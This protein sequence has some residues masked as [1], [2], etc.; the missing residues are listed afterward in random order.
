MAEI[1][2]D[3]RN[4]AG[5]IVGP[6]PI[7]TATN[8]HQEKRVDEAGSFSFDMPASDDKHLD[9]VHNGTVEIYSNLTGIAVQL[10]AGVVE[11]IQ[12][13]VGDPSMINV[14]GGDLLRELARYPVGDTRIY[15][16]EWKSLSGGVGEVWWIDGAGYDAD[17]NLTEAYDGD[18]GTYTDPTFKLGDHWWLCVGTDMPSTADKYLLKTV[19]GELVG[20]G[21]QYQY[22]SDATGWTDFT[23]LTDGTKVGSII[24]AQDGT[25]SWDRPVD[26][27]RNRI[28]PTSGSKFWRRIRVDKLAT[29]ATA[30]DIS[31]YEIESY[32]DTPSTAGVEI[33][34]TL[35][36]YY[37]GG[38]WAVVSTATS[39]AAYLS[40]NGESVLTALQVLAES[41]G[42]HFILGTGREITWIGPASTW[43]LGDYGA[44]GDVTGEEAELAN[45]HNLLITN[46]SKVTDTAELITRIVPFAGSGAQR[47]DLSNATST[48]PAGYTLVVNPASPIQ[49][50]LENDAAVATYG[51]VAVS[52]FF[53][54]ILNQADGS[55]SMGPVYA[56]NQLYD[57]AKT[58]LDTHCVPATHYELSVAGVRDYP[59]ALVSPATKQ[60]IV[61]QEWTDGVKTLDINTYPSSPLYVMAVDYQI[62]AEGAL[63]A[64]MEVSNV[65]RQAET[66]ASVTVDTIQTV[67]QLTGGVKSMTGGSSNIPDHLHTTFGVDGGKLKDVILQ[68]S[69]DSRVERIVSVDNQPGG[70]NYRTPLLIKGG[71]GAHGEFWAN[72]G[73]V[74]LEGGDGDIPGDIRLRDQASKISAIMDTTEL[75]SGDKIFTW[76]NKSGTIATTDDIGG[77]SGDVAGPAGAVDSN[78]AAF[79]T[80]T[81]KKIK[82]SGYNAASF[83]AALGADDNYVTDAEKIVIGNT[84]GTN[85]GDNAANSQI[86]V[87][88]VGSEIDTGTDDAKFVTAKA[89]NDSHNVP[90]VAPSTAGNYMKSN[91]TDW[92]SANWPTVT[93]IVP[94]HRDGDNDTVY[95]KTYNSNTRVRFWAFYLPFRIVISQIVIKTGATVTQ[96]GTM[97]LGIY[98]EDGQTKYI[99]VTTPTLSA[100]STVYAVAVS[101]SVTLL[102]GVY[103]GAIVCIGTTN[104]TLK[105]NPG[106]ADQANWV[107]NSKAVEEGYHDYASAGVVPASFSPTA[108]LTFSSQS[109]LIMR[110]DT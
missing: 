4:V 80:N 60:H 37:S 102:P 64:S 99:D 19:N 90:D 106:S 35:A 33:L 18:G 16:Q 41:T 3:V 15:G 110:F 8:W 32:L 75:D 30:G 108:D 20:T 36:N 97:Q 1:W 53:N 84:S 72:G 17:R 67:R 94:K 21:E 31:I 24:F 63:L 48:P 74:I 105:V 5:T 93:S 101:P 92:I 7:T 42:D 27:V 81:G 79:D 9:L 59:G 77:G 85:S 23:G 91:G 65:E 88:A 22:Y 44:R 56:A 51:V 54:D 43:S 58:Y 66:G 96:S 55:E 39:T 69:P 76:P 2:V 10:G 13:L 14:S 57:A 38:A 73:G 52:H 28:T 87:K 26:W 45:E 78:F 70:G 11:K 68:A 40:F 98:S 29:G 12:E 107:L 61:W 34:T 25:I 104:V 95:D 62:S 46:L 6:G 103:Y 86:P 109:N 49:P 82:D 100:T 47:L 83:A 71:P 89:I 50:Y